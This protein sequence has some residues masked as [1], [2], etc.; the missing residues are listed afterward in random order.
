VITNSPTRSRFTFSS[1]MVSLCILPLPTASCPIR[2]RPTA[3]VPRA[4]APNASTP[5]AC[6]PIASAP[7][8][9]TYAR[10]RGIF[11]MGAGGG[12]VVALVVGHV[13]VCLVPEDFD[14]L[15]LWLAP[16]MS[17]LVSFVGA[18]LCALGYRR[19]RRLL[20]HAGVVPADVAIMTLMYVSCPWVYFETDPPKSSMRRYGPRRCVAR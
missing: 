5:R 6:A 19:S 18:F 13:P 20:R 3:S 11:L 7:T 2:R 17:A 16:P 4:N 14:A 15:P 9:Q 12:A 8:E 1:S 10:L